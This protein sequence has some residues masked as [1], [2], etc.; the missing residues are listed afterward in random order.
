MRSG[1]LLRACL[2]GAF[3]VLPAVAGADAPQP[4][5]HALGVAEGM[6]NYC[7]S[8]DPASAEQVRQVIK[9]L[10]QGASE[11]QLAEVRKSDDYRKAYD[12]VADFTA[13]LEPRNAK[14]FCSESLA[15]SK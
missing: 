13:K 3:L 8:V 2:V 7:G 1:T 9:Q 15:A 14:H 11:L 5:P 6:I 12:S 4:D 10:M